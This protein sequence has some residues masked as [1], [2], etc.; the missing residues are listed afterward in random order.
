MPVVVQLF[1]PTD[2]APDPATG[3]ICPGDTLLLTARN[4]VAY[5]WS[6]ATSLSDAG[7]DSTLAYPADNTDYTIEIVDSNGCTFLKEVPVDVYPEAYADAGDDARVFFGTSITLD[8]SGN[9]QA[10]WSP[11]RWLND[12]TVLQPVATPDSSLTYFLEITTINGCMAFDSVYLEV[13]YETKMFMPNA[14]SPN[15]D[16][17]NDKFGPKWLNEFELDEFIIFNRWGQV[18]FKTNNP[19]H[20]WDGTLHGEP[21][22]VGTYVYVIRGTGNRGETFYKKGNVTL[23]R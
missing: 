12:P 17:K 4:G 10:Q 19:D 7:N 23:I 9:G 14:F 15:G 22:P 18:V 6:P 2:P 8:A 3:A 21:Q 5:S 11:L 13:F 16:G 1:E 20:H